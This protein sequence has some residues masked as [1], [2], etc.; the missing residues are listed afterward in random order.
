MSSKTKATLATMDA[1]NFETGKQNNP[2]DLTSLEEVLGT[3][4]TEAQ[5]EYLKEYWKAFYNN[6]L[7]YKGSVVLD[8]VK[9]DLNQKFNQ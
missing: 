5:T 1:F 6:P 4:L 3:Q 8:M 7:S 2:S 9:Q